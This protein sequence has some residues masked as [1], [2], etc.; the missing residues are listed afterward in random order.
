MWE[1]DLFIRL[2][3]SMIILYIG[4]GIF[5]SH[6]NHKKTNFSADRVKIMY[7]LNMEQASWNPF[8]TIK[9]IYDSKGFV[10]FNA[11]WQ[12]RLSH[13]LPIIFFKL[14]RFMF[15]LTFPFTGIEVRTK[16]GYSV[17][18]Y[19]HFAISMV[20]ALMLSKSCIEIA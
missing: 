7:Q 14:R 8:A 11:G 6:S 10:G 5:L 2:A 20:I 17:D 18:S 3:F 12:Y 16:L 9:Y 15:L 1:L 4:N 19:I 13:L